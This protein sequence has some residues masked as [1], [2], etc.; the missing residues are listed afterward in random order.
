MNEA[1]KKQVEELKI[2]VFATTGCI[3][4]QTIQEIDVKN[5]WQGVRAEMVVFSCK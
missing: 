3:H 5:L 2:L 4:Q 1:T